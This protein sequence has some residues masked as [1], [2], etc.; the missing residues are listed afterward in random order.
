MRSAIRF[1]RARPGLIFGMA[2]SI[3]AFALWRLL[4]MPSP[5]IEGRLLP[6][7]VLLAG[8]A[9]P[10]RGPG[11]AG[12]VCIAVFTIASLLWQVGGLAFVICRVSLAA[13]CIPSCISAARGRFGMARALLPFAPIIILMVPFTGDEP[14]NAA[15][16]ESIW[17]DGDLNTTNNL[18]QL[19]PNSAVEPE[20]GD[21][22]GISHHLPLFALLISPGLLLGSAGIRILCLIVSGISGLLILKVLAKAHA[23]DPGGWA[24]LGMLLLPGAGILGLA[25][26]DWAAAGLV[27]AGALAAGKR[28]RIAVSLILALALT[29][30]KTRYAPAGA[31]LVAAAVLSSG[32]KKLVPAVLLTVAAV[33]AV[34]VADRF[35][36]GGRLFWIRYGNLEFLRTLLYRTAA[37]AGMM[38]SAPF[39]ALFDSEAGLLWRAPW[40]LVVP[41]GAAAFRRRAPE[42]F[43]ALA[44]ASALYTIALFVW[45]PD[46]WHSSP[47]PTGRLFVPLIPFLVG[48]A[49]FAA[50][51]SRPVLALSAVA[52]ALSM[53][54]PAVRFNHMDGTDVFISMVAR[55]GGP[56]LQAAL[57]SSVRPDALV[58]LAWLGVAAAAFV[59]VHR[60]NGR[61][62]A[63][64]LAA[65]FMAASFASR[66][67]TAGVYEAE[68]LAA[69]F[70]IG[71]GLYPESDDPMLRN[72]WTDSR[73][74][75]LR[76]SNGMD[77]VILPVPATDAWGTASITLRGDPS[78][79]FGLRI[80]CGSV[81]TLV[82]PLAVPAPLPPWV[83]EVRGGR[84]VRRV[85]AGD[86]LEET[87]EVEL[88]PGPGRTLLLRA[89]GPP[90]ATDPDQGIFL[91]RIVLR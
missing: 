5:G 29:A 31:G 9:S 44:W 89:D 87:V 75:L 34:L 42:A 47:T 13:C 14:Y 88:E 51:G 26:P 64:L 19:D 78:G 35:A 12:Q 3:W 53:A 83:G 82:H 90:F 45:L 60:R 32:R 59:L 27:A 6:L 54:I 48:C 74:R 20:H 15:L 77:A 80:T 72:A 23:P 69:D 33:T 21:L 61:A 70:R 62:V 57:P 86:L 65:A 50:R 73:E 37:E 68:D 7:C 11:R 85:A 52:T 63:Y 41:A 91:D 36:L 39:W 58:A 66:A 46:F 2:A 18:R 55:L 16:G 38:I 71:C 22:G 49:A 4:G 8:V 25:Y 56:G 79:D 84:V 28:R 17:V 10:S 67:M 43:R 40:L 30:L 81:D 1:L 76:L 24:A